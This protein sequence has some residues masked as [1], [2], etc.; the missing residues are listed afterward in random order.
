M[1][2]SLVDV[3]VEFLERRKS[4]VAC[5]AHTGQ[6]LENRVVVFGS[7]ADGTAEWRHLR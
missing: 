2:S 7:S 5:V 4:V 6:L 3:I 1:V